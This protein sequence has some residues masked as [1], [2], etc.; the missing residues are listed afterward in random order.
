MDVANEYF[1]VLVVRYSAKFTCKCIVDW[2][3]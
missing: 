2:Q 1:E 3:G